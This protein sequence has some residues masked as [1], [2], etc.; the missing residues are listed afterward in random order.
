MLAQFMSGTNVSG[1]FQADDSH[2]ELLRAVVLCHPGWAGLRRITFAPDMRCSPT[3]LRWK[4]EVFA[5]VL[6]QGMEGAH[7]ACAA[8]DCRGLAVFDSA[9]DSALPPD[10]GKAS[11]VAGAA[12][13]E[14]YSAPKSEKLWPRY[15]TLVISGDV[16]GHLAILCALRGA[17][18]HLPPAAI[19]SAYI[20]LEAKGGLPRSGIA[21]WVR[22]VGD[23]LT[24]RHG[25]KNSNLRAA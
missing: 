21:L 14:G 10:L 5:P 9:I 19:A 3:W 4:E 22:M 15:R 6:L 25:L 7:F 2:V 20:F 1:T 11:R 23:C 16:P 8:G 12:L 13:M 24:K 18:F 17:A